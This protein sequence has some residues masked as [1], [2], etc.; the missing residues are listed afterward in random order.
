MA[1]YLDD[2]DTKVY[3]NMWEVYEV[4]NILQRDNNSE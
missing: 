3:T 2:P 1:E 4:K